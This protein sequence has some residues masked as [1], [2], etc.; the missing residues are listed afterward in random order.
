MRIK[1]RILSKKSSEN[2]KYKKLLEHLIK[3]HSRNNLRTKN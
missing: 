2:I 3:Q 1:T